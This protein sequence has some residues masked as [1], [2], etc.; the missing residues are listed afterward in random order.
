MTIM[1]CKQDPVIRSGVTFCATSTLA[2]VGLRRVWAHWAS[3]AKQS[4]E[5]II[6]G[7]H[8]LRGN[9]FHRNRMGYKAIGTIAACTLHGG[10]SGAHSAAPHVGFAR[11]TVRNDLKSKSDNSDMRWSSVAWLL[12]AAVKPHVVHRVSWSILH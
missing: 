3:G 5:G 1:Q 12:S 8:A 7:A 4:L 9:T 11:V 10:P 6:D 2:M